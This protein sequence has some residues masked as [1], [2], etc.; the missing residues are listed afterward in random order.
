MEQ[1]EAALERDGLASHVSEIYS[2]PR[3]T[4]MAEKMGLVSGMAL[5]LTTVD[6]DDGKPWDFNIKD[7]RDKA[8][9]LL[10]TRR[11]LLLIGSP[12]CAA[13]SQLQNMNWGNMSEEDMSR[14]KEYGRVHL[15][16]CV[17]L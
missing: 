1:M 16:F 17:K 15:E 4:S 7:K 11:S 14:V 2:K 8:L 9:K 13:F 3:V 6:P 12:M 10:F 5:D